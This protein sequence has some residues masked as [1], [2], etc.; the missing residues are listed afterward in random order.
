[1][2]PADHRPTGASAAHSPD[3]TTFWR[4]DPAEE[5]GNAA[6]ERVRR[7]DGGALDGA[8]GGVRIAHRRRDRDVGPAERPGP[9]TDRG[10]VGGLEALPFSVLIFVFGSLLLVN[11]W[12]V[13]DAKLAVTSASRE[14]TRTFAESNEPGTGAEAARR[15]AEDAISA[16]GRDPDRLDLDGPHGRLERCGTVSYTA[17]YPVPALRIPLIGGY[18][19]GF[20]VTSTHTELVDGLRSGLPGEADCV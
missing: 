3:R 8:R 19:R 13:V 9:G 15:A 10:A 7:G 2:P 14:A 12:G 1:M 16:Y 4:V 11:A 5:R 17:T 20:D 6:P 18:G